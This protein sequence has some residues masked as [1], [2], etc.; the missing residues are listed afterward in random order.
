[1]IKEK[2]SEAM[3]ISHQQGAQIKSLQRCH[4]QRPKHVD[5]TARPVRWTRVATEA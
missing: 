1:M 4:R 5:R 3:V 2:L